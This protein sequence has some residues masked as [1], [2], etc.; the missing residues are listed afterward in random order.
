MTVLDDY[1][2]RCCG[3]WNSPI[4]MSINPQSVANIFN[5][6]KTVE[7]RKKFPKDFIGWIYIYCTKTK[8]YLHEFCQTN[9]NHGYSCIEE[10]Y[11]NA[12][13]GKIVAR[14][15]CDKVNESD[16]IRD[17]LIG[18]YLEPQ[19]ISDYLKGH[20]GYAIHIS[21]L[22]IFYEPIKLESK[23]PKSWQ[24]LHSRLEENQHA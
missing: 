21:H 12:L 3:R 16:K 2:F 1:L 7:I 10:K 9:G 24:Y 13:N 17:F 18:S 15:W 8:P 23:A 19:D 14:F 11:G 4:L 20:K 22:E 5:G 6:E